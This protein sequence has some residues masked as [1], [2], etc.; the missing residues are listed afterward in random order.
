MLWTT[1]TPGGGSVRYA[2]QPMT[3]GNIATLQAELKLI[4]DNVTN[5]NNKGPSSAQYG[6]LM[7]DAWKYFGGY[8]N[9]SGTSTPVNSTHFGTDV[10]LSETNK[11]C[12][13]ADLTAY[14]SNTCVKFVP[15]LSSS[16]SCGKNYVI[17][18]GNNGDSRP[19]ADD[20]T[21]ITGVGGTSSGIS[22]PDVTWANINQDVGFSNACSSSGSP[23]VAPYTVAGDCS[24][25]SLVADTTRWDTTASCSSTQKKWMIQCQ[26]LGEAVVPNSSTVENDGRL[27]DNWA[28]FMYKGDAS[29]AP[30]Q[31]GITTYTIDVYN[32]AANKVS[33]ETSS[34][35]MSMANVSAGNYYVAKSL[36]QIK[37]ALAD[38]FSKILASNSV[39]ASASLPISATNRQV[40]DNAVFIGQFRPD[41][42]AQPRW[43]G[44][45]KKYQ[46]INGTNGIEL[47]D[48]GNPGQPAVDSTT[49]FISACATSFW[50]TDSGTWWD[51]VPE[52]PIP[53][54]TCIPPRT[55]FD[56]FSDSPD[57]PFV[58]KGS[59]AEVVR[60][61]NNPPTTNATPT[62]LVNR[63]VNTLN[64]GATALATFSTSTAPNILSR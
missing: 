13:V 25:G 30:G 34:M 53:K 49:G 62:W 60:K 20:A 57:G 47:G 28:K 29:A 43:M 3:T 4:H 32:A 44:N 21:L 7:F 12:T 23:S 35:L 42:D 11:S 63:T 51:S 9:D 6:G 46:L 16:S 38:I 39:F 48:S 22:R 37:I 19:N 58:E 8:A 26:F 31:Q 10:F 64:S 17:F 45:M 24:V 59:V 50:T 40:S 5:S 33:P 18:I 56:P 15:A 36:Q 1:N 52:T 61:G 55:M 41:P 2:M 14:T 54:G 27:A